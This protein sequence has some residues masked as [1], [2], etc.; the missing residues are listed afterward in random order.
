MTDPSAAPAPERAAEDT[1]AAEAIAEGA[2]DASPAAFLADATA[3]YRAR[4]EGHAVLLSFAEYLEAVA[5]HPRAHARDAATYLRDCITHYGTETVARPYGEFTR[6]RI[7]DAPH[8]DGR[9]PVEGHETVQQEV[10]GLLT[11]FVRGGRV[12]RLILLNGP[13]GSAKS[14]FVAALARGLEA[15]SRLP[16]GALYTFNWVFP[17]ARLDRSG[18]GFGNVRRLD[19]I[20]SY[21]HL[22]DGDIDARIRCETRDHPLLLLPRDDRVAFLRRH[23]GPDAPLPQSITD[24]ALSPK[25]HQIMDALLTAYRGDLGEVLKHVQIER[26]QVSRRYRQAAVTVD[27][28]MRVDAGMRQLT[29]DRSLGSLPPSLHTLTLFEPMGDLVDGNRGLVEYND[30]LKRHPEAFKY[31]L[32]TCE[33]GAVRLETMTLQLDAVLF[34]TCNAGHLTEFK[35]TPDYASFK[36]RM[37][38]VE[39][40]YLVDYT[41]EARIYRAVLDDLGGEVAIGP[42]VAD[43]LALWAVLCRLERP[44]PREDA[45]PAVQEALQKMGPLDKARLYA[46]GRVPDRVPRD[47]ANHL[48]A[49]VPELYR[50][51]ATHEHYEGRFGPSSRTLKAMLLSTARHSGACITGVTVLTALAELV[52]ETAVHPFLAREPDGEWYNPRKAIDLV[53]A[54]Y[55]DRV[56]EE[57]H[58]AMGLV[59]RVATAELWRR[60]IDHAVHFVRGE[61]RI[62][63]ITGRPED[64]DATL[65]SDVEK[66]VGVAAGDRHDFR[67]GA[68]HRIAA[69]RMDHPEGDLDYA[70]IFREQIA[71]LGDS[72]YDEKRKLADRVKRDLLTHLATD[73]RLADDAL[74][75]VERTLTALRDDFGYQTA[76]AVE[77]IGFLLRQ[78]TN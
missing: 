16:E 14:R 28:Q 30:L 17:S 1:A 50:E 10:I 73:T 62:N 72:F 24:G 59:D 77:V 35:K 64:P 7:F 19:E 11:D 39:M 3:R 18:I 45:P 65:M 66:R 23:L 34:G 36:A 47:V 46:T 13:N 53:R 9:Q 6:Y 49:L 60:Y 5:E 52:Q 8:D 61:K 44:L 43:V 56:E 48:L 40:P 55:L 41:L 20:A 22:R 63:P 71:R 78:R 68:V 12:D 57:L 51:R 38:L 42:H 67:E 74:A 69:W 75:A 21:A 27:P 31:L 4:F 26:F 70:D 76:C 15:Y 58:Q 29:A 33:T 2:A 25:A 37:E 54:W 32:S